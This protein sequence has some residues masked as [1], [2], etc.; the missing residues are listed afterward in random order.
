M[1][2]YLLNDYELTGCQIA[3]SILFSEYACRHYTEANKCTSWKGWIVHSLIGTAEIIPLLG[4]IF[5]IAERCFVSLLQCVTGKDLNELRKRTYPYYSGLRHGGVNDSHPPIFGSYAQGIFKV[6]A[7]DIITDYSLDKL[8]DLKFTFLCNGK[9]FHEA[10]ESPTHQVF[11]TFLLNL[12]HESEVEVKLSAKVGY[13]C[14]IES[15]EIKFTVDKA[16]GIYEVIKGNSDF[17]VESSQLPDPV[18]IGPSTSIFS[19]GSIGMGDR[20]IDLPLDIDIQST[21]GLQ[22]NYQTNRTSA[23]EHYFITNHS[24]FTNV[25]YF[26]LASHVDKFHASYDGIVSVPVVVPAGE[27][28]GVSK[29]FFIDSWKTAYRLAMNNT[30]PDDPKLSLFYTLQRSYGNPLVK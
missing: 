8:T 17:F 11:E 7:S 29:Q 28:K 25:I 12:P 20:N 26:E 13:N 27:T 18:T 19:H 24:N 10:I 9:V 4:A 30:P 1:T 21:G 5:S 16:N 3:K 6:K 15:D 23:E 22:F 14:G 2:Y